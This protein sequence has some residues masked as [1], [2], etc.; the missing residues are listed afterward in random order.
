MK[1]RICIVGMSMLLCMMCGCLQSTP[2]TDEEL[3]VV[4]EYAA[5]LL[6]KYDVN[7]DSPLYYVEEMTELL[8]PTPTPTPVVT[9][10]P[11]G[12][13][14]GMQGNGSSVVPGGTDP[15][16]TIGSINDAET[17]KQLTQVIAEENFSI[18]CENFELMDAVESNDYFSLVAKE[19]RQ[20]AVV[21]FRLHN[22]TEQDQIFDAS[23][24]GLEY[25]LDINV[26]TVSRVSLS[27]LENDMQ[28]MP[29]TVPAKGEAEAVLVFEI[30][31]EEI[32]TAHLM[33]SNKAEETVFIKVYG[34]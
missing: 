14:S 29:I 15:E 28:Y 9:P 30:G 10:V 3:D 17:N 5:N 1:K 8:S 7:Y 12:A 32:N 2:L 19:G 6:L 26:G 21:T 34:K 31:T 11:D 23:E 25:L 13:E 18:T 22:N 4:A 27:M 24:N 16:V 20:Y 33:I